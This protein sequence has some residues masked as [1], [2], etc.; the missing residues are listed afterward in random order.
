[1]VVGVLHPDH[2]HALGARLVDQGVDFRD[3][4]VAVVGVGHYPVLDVDHE[5]R[6]VPPIGQRRHGNLLASHVLRR[7]R[8]KRRIMQADM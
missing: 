1:M 4:T 7:R 2:R 3:H 8:R 6:G 5:Q